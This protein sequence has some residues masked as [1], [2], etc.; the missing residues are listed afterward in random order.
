MSKF[1][2]MAKREKA[3]WHKRLAAEVREQS[4]LAAKQAAEHKK[5][6]HN[7]EK[8]VVPHLEWAVRGFGKQGIQAKIERSWLTDPACIPFVT[9]HCRGLVRLPGGERLLEAVGATIRI[10]HDPNE[11]LMV[12]VDSPGLDGVVGFG[13]KLKQALDVA[14]Q[15]AL[16]TYMARSAEMQSWR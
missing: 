5:L 14:A 4:R 8:H 15:Y 2:T 16:D 10:I 3:E 7:L 13:G 12:R 9:F 11:D 6:V 1:A